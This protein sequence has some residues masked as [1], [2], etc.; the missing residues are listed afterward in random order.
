MIITNKNLGDM[1]KAGTF[2]DDL[3]FRLNVFSL[4]LPQLRE[5]IEDI[6]HLIERFMENL[7]KTAVVSSGALQMLLRY[8]WPGNIRELENVI[9]HAFVLCREGE[10][11]PRHLPAPFAACIPAAAGTRDLP[12][13]IRSVEAQAIR[14]ALARNHNNRLAAARELGLHKSTL[15]RKIKE[16]GLSLPDEDGRSRKKPRG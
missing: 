6:P 8:P 13:L 14:D 10:I 1:V 5:R 3:F 4:H 12:A 7:G 2:R 9:E 15:F 16:L 11:E